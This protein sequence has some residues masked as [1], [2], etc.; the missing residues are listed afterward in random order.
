M[1][2]EKDRAE[3]VDKIF[4]Q[5]ILAVREICVRREGQT[6]HNIPLVLPVAWPGGVTV[7]AFD[8]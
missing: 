5:L 3:A 6:H 4:D 7:T 8:L 2:P 1:L